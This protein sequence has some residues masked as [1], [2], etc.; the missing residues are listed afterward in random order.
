MTKL[1]F[2]D[3]RLPGSVWD[4]VSLT[5]DGCWLVAGT[6]NGNGYMRMTIDGRRQYL[7]HIVALLEMGP[8]LEGMIRDH[9]CHDV[10]TCQ[11][12]ATCPHRRCIRHIQYIPVAE[13][14]SRAR[15]VS[16]TAET[17]HCPKGHPY[18]AGNTKSPP[19]FNGRRI[20]HACRMAYQRRWRA[21]KRASAA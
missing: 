10:T 3:A 1:Q 5:A 8:L 18:D 16:R 7:H 6:D 20:C 9:S 2:G 4:R 19:S 11:G 21:K 13:N 15:A 14:S 17:T 12:G